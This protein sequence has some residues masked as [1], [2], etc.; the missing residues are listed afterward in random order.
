M[1]RRNPAKDVTRFL[2]MLFGLAYCGGLA[3]YLMPYASFTKDGRDATPTVM[4]LS[5]IGILIGFGFVVF[6][7]R[8]IAGY[9]GGGDDGAR[10]G[11]DL[12]EDAAV[13]SDFDADEIIARYMA[14]GRAPASAN[15]EPAPQSY[16]PPMHAAPAASPATRQ[17]FG[18][19][20]V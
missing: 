19:K 20:P 14:Q 1:A 4:G 11:V 5:I 9:M 7:V 17:G 13:R 12:E 18:R 15:S 3:W 10:K 2:S 6:I 8:A 16:A